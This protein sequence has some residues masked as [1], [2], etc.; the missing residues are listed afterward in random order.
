MVGVYTIYNNW[1]GLWSDKTG[2]REYEIIIKEVIEFVYVHVKLQ[3]CFIPVR[4]YI[5]P[6]TKFTV[7]PSNIGGALI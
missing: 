1:T 7:Y 4:M 6:H 2:N 3:S 5:E